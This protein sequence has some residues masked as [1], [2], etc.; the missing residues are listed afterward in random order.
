MAKKYVNGY[1]KP[2]FTIIDSDNNRTTIDLSFRYNA[3][4]EFYERTSIS[5]RS[6]GGTIL[7]KSLYVTFEW[8]LYYTDYIEK[9]D[10]LKIQQIEQAD[11]DGKRI[12]LMPHIDYPWREHEV[13][14]VDEKRTVGLMY[15]GGGRESTANRGIEITFVVKYPSQ[16]MQMV[17]PDSIPVISAEVGFE[18][19]I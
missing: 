9:D 14:I 1:D 7:K 4:T 19:G 12:L 6:L 3:L 5:K 16:G 10:L 13:V 8:R 15:H 2:R 18:Y 11:M 17:D